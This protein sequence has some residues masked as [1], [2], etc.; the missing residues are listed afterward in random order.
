[1]DIQSVCDLLSYDL[2]IELK[3]YFLCIL[4]PVKTHDSVVHTAAQNKMVIFDHYII[5]PLE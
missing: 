4:L 5:L 2:K 3:Q 1:M